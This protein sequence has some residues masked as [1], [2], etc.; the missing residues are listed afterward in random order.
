MLANL[1]QISEPRL[2][3]DWCSKHN[4]SVIAKNSDHKSAPKNKVLV[5]PPNIPKDFTLS[6]RS[7]TKSSITVNCRGR[8]KT[9]AKAKQ[10]GYILVSDKRSF[11]GTSAFQK[12]LK[13]N[14]KNGEFQILIGIWI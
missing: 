4:I 6:Q 10:F 14:K 1:L 9:Y 5:T 7:S 13:E 11:D 12:A 2:K 3:L 8:N